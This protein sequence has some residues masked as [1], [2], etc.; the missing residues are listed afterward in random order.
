FRPK[1]KQKELVWIGRIMVFIVS[2]IAILLA[3][4]PNNS[5]LDLVSHA[6]AGFGA[7]FG[8]IIIFSVFWSR[9][10]RNGALAGMITGAVTVLL[11]INFNWFNLYSLIPGFILASIAIIIFS[12]CDKK[13]SEI[14]QVHF[15]DAY[16]RYHT[17]TK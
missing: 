17:K 5:V 2:V 6:W 3:I 10:T 4:N 13:P 15:K 8:P 14:V 1:A 7:A 11:W 16:K 9:M 12:L